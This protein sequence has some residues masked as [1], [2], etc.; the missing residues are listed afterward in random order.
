MKKLIC[1]LLI[2][3]F[4]LTC[5]SIYAEA[6]SNS[7]PK[8]KKVQIKKC[9][10]KKI[11]LQWKKVKTAKYYQVKVL[12][13][14][15]KKY[16]F[17]KRVKAKKKR[18]KKTV[19][20][21]S[22]NKNYYF[23]V[24]A[25]KKKICGKWSKR[26]KGKTKFN[27]A[28]VNEDTQAS[29][30]VIAVDSD[31][32]PHVISYGE[33]D[34]DILYAYKSG[35]SWVNE[36][37]DSEGNVGDG[38][39]IITDQNNIPH[40]SY[41][42]ITNKSMKYATKVDGEWSTKTIDSP[43]SPEETIASSTIDLNSQGYPH[44]AYCTESSSNDVSLDDDEANDYLKYAFWNGTAWSIDTSEI[45]GYWSRIALDSNDLAH[46]AF[47]QNFKLYYTTR[48]SSGNWAE[49]QAIDADTT[50][51]S[52]PFIVVDSNNL[53]RIVYRDASGN[54][55]IRYAA[56]DG[57]N[58]NITIIA[59][60]IEVSDETDLALDSDNNPYIVYG[61]QGTVKLASLSNGQ[62]TS[63]AVASG[64]V[65]SL[66][67]DQLDRVHVARIDGSLIKYKLID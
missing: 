24:R 30:P 47:L 31:N 39:D 23:R 61:D 41:R 11:K 50:I 66:A 17:V 48:D 21:L 37:I 19:K 18:N 13:K 3:I 15:N 38:H 8:V 25:C 67:V 59:E 22:Y 33:G 9:Y 60:N 44:I 12:K 16:K 35:N 10:P 28:W 57:N 4:S 14:P 6:A 36:T 5:F 42:D 7:L 64:G 46:I 40:V 63:E 52:D 45:D 20:K 34:W 62:W 49:P 58:W 51:E 27:P 55:D 26:K 65:C 29:V 54:G 56:Y 53:P 32:I 2:A 43:S 1:A